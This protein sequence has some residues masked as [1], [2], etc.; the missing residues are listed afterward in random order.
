MA[1]KFNPILGTLLVVVATV[2]LHVSDAQGGRKILSTGGD[3]W[4]D[5]P[6]IKDPKVIE[7]GKFAVDEH[8]KDAKT[9]L[10][11]VEIKLAKRQTKPTETTINYRM[12]IRVKDDG[13]DDF[14]VAEV[15]DKQKEKSRNLISFVECTKIKVG[16]EC[17]YY[18]NLVD[19][20]IRSERSI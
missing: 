11:F 4:V 12:I 2:L 6:D 7:I 3:D 10:E 13:S 18:D 20:I 14:Y 16:F 1:I 19:K 5:I 9:K 15:S 8:N 17:Y